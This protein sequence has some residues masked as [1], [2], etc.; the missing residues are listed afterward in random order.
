MRYASKHGFHFY[1][2]G[3]FF[4]SVGSADIIKLTSKMKFTYIKGLENKVSE[5]MEHIVSQNNG[6]ERFEAKKSKI[7]PL[8]VSRDN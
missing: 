7:R 3:K 5:K 1:A 2:H 4:L 8:H 6:P